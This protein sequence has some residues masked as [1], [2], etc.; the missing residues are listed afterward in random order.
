MRYVIDLQK[1]GPYIGPRGGKWADPEHTIPYKE[2]GPRMG[3]TKFKREMDRRRAEGCVVSGPKTFQYKEIIKAAGGVW[4]SWEKQWLVLTR[5]VAT[6]LMD[7]MRRG[8]AITPGQV[9]KK[10][11]KEAEPVKDAAGDAGVLQDV[12]VQQIEKRQEPANAKEIQRVKDAVADCRK[13]V[14]DAWDPLKQ[15][16]LVSIRQDLIDEDLAQLDKQEIAVLLDAVHAI[17]STELRRWAASERRE[18]AKVREVNRREK[19]ALDRG[20]FWVQMYRD[21]ERCKKG[22]IFLHYKWGYLKVTKLKAITTRAGM[23][24]TRYYVKTR[25]ASDAMVKR[26]RKAEE[27]KRKATPEYQQEQAYKE[28]LKPAVDYKQRHGSLF[29]GTVTMASEGGKQESMVEVPPQLSLK[30][31]KWEIVASREEGG[32]VG[33]RA[34]NVHILHRAILPDGRPIYKEVHDLGFGDSL[35]QTFHLPDDVHQA[36]LMAE[37]KARGITPEKA[38]EWLANYKGCVDTELYEFALKAG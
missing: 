5:E 35:R 28:A 1:A 31:L 36:S 2:P 19:E 22:Q 34:M 10:P 21:D 7:Y 9:K 6:K 13:N 25:R 23:T 29:G 24:S 14:H 26:W 32:R 38:K 27:E 17:E 20:E 16:G 33:G 4:D 3:K 37:V 8:G 18:Q 15:M 11:M 30:D 12:Q